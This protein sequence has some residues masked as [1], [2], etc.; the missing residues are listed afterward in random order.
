MRSGK[1][2]RSLDGTSIL[3]IHLKYLYNL[4]KRPLLVINYNCGSTHLLYPI[5]KY[6]QDDFCLLSSQFYIEELAN[7]IDRYLTDKYD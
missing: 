4:T 3:I 6:R 1:V 7:I 2:C 5:Q